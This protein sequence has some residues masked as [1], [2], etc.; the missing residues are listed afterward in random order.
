MERRP[1][2]TIGELVD[3]RYRLLRL[4][5]EGGMG[6]VYEAEHVGIGKRVALKILHAMFSNIDEVVT[7][8]R[9]EARIAT[10][11]GNPHIVDVTDSGKT[12]DGRFYFVMEYLDGIELHAAIRSGALE[13]VRA[14]RIARQIA[15]ALAAAHDEGVIHRDLKPENIL[16]VD[17]DGEPDFV[18]VLDF[19]IARWVGGE[20]SKRRLT[21]PGLAMGTPEYMA[22]EQALALTTD[23]RSDV[24]SLGAILYEMLTGSQPYRADTFTQVL[25]LK[26]STEPAPP[27]Q[28][29]E[30]IPEE[31]E[32]IVLKAMSREPDARHQTMAE[33][34][35]EISKVVEGRD[36]AVSRILGMAAPPLEERISVAMPALPKAVR[37]EPEVPPA[38]A[39]EIE[40][41]ID[42]VVAAEDDEVVAPQ[43]A[44]E[45]PAEAVAPTVPPPAARARGVTGR[46]WALLL[47]LACVGGAASWWLYFRGDGSSSPAPAARTTSAAR[48]AT[49]EAPA[50][51]AGTPA[52]PGDSTSPAATPESP[53][54]AA[55]ARPPAPRP[56]PAKVGTPPRTAKQARAVL[57]KA[58][59]LAK[60]G[61]RA[62]AIKQYRLLLKGQPKNRVARRELDALTRAPATR[63]H[64]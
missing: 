38:I 13:V 32:A 7:R 4:M 60:A 62:E 46:T 59:A 10:K 54:P 63:K 42:E 24:Y 49:S 58:R 36:V 41:P 12:E 53:A 28:V 56:A 9:Q 29:R 48:R 61:K 8:F 51:A 3:D 27:R 45:V 21:Q 1:R 11:I 22:P 31:V 34:S 23:A 33:L 25:V 26:S 57:T 14:L 20:S 5:G 35:Y 52:R 55:T 15:D 30:E 2:E 64:R 17:R 39:L 47:S 37:A 19:G 44:A 43:V 18:K 6:R 50:R 40:P 16:L